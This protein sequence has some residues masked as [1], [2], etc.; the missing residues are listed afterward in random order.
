MQEVCRP[1]R[2]YSTA[3]APLGDRTADEHWKLGLIYYNPADP[4]LFIEKRFG[5]GYTM[6]MARPV[7]WVMLTA[8]LVLPLLLI[9]LFAL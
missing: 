7:V 4:A 3:G 9:L 5:I 2:E 1:R 8:L 6:N